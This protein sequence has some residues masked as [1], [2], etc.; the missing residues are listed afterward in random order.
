ML[1][2]GKVFYDLKEQREQLA[3]DKVALVRVEQVYPFPSAQLTTILARYPQAR[4]LYWVQ[5]EPKN[6]G[7]WT[8][9]R[10]LLEEIL[11]GAEDGARFTS[12]PLASPHYLGRVA[13]ASPATGSA[14]SHAL[15]RK[16]IL[17]E[18]FANLA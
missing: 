5:E 1:S 15:E 12:G 11:A 4:E 17:E 2:A 10:P 3:T 7:C 9:V 8:F 14:D 16:L 18:A 13:S 6:M